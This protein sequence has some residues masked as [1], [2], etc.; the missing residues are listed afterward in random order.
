MNKNIGQFA[1]E[2]WIILLLSIFCGSITNIVSPNRISVIYSANNNPVFSGEANPF[3]MNF[4][5]I[6]SLNQ[7]KEYFDSSTAVFIDARPF[8]KYIESHI[9]GAISL[10][11]VEFE[12][13]YEAI[14]SRLPVNHT[15]I[16]YCDNVHCDLSVRLA[17][18]LIK[19]GHL[20]CYIFENGTKH[21]QAVNYPLEAS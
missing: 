18:Q 12:D 5:Q 1:W 11:L 8:E 15:L 21:W 17:Y 7:A 13:K 19:K 20:Y 9:P 10:P 6:I 2:C 16:V 14:K 4:P 3:S